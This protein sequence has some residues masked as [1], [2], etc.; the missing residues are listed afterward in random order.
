MIRSRELCAKAHEW[1]AYGHAV[2]ATRVN[3]N[4]ETDNALSVTAKTFHFVPQRKETGCHRSK[5]VL[6]FG[7]VAS[8][9][10][11]R[12]RARLERGGVISMDIA[13]RTR[14]LA[15]ALTAFVAFFVPL[16]P[17]AAAEP[18]AEPGEWVL[19]ILLL[20]PLGFMRIIAGVPFFA[21]S[22]PFVAFREGGVEESWDFFVDEPVESTFEREIG[23]F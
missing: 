12:R 15:L 17:T 4:L 10:V 5:P 1:R 8:L 6:R 13:A 22:V 18:A 3:T 23:D 21:V 2:L 11:R 7:G 9:A 19:E 14:Q 16:A 20:R